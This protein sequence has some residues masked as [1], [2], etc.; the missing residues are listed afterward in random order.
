MKTEDA[1]IQIIKIQKDVVQKLKYNN[2]AL[3]SLSS[4]IN[5]YQKNSLKTDKINEEMVDLF[6]NYLLDEVNGEE[7]ELLNEVDNTLDLIIN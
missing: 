6:I 2:D 4:L 7:N 5:F 3:F 1:L